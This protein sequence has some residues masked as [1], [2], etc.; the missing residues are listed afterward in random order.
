[1]VLPKP[2]VLR[3]GDFVMNKKDPST[4]LLDK[5]I[6]I[7]AI[8]RGLRAQGAARLRDAAG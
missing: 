6:A 3:Y 2:K 8:M 7:N 5:P 4:L 1:M